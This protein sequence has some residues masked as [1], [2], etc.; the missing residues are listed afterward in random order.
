MKFSLLEPT[1]LTIEDPKTYRL[2]DRI[3]EADGVQFLCPVCF[4]QNQ[5]RV[6]THSIICWR[7]HVSQEVPP[8]PGRWEFK[9]TGYG[10]L[11]L[12]AGSSS[13]LLRTS[14]CKAHFFVENGEVRMT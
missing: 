4:M 8:T 11:T 5:G 1:F 14:P 6:G 10:D 3:G 9:G 2:T 7:P 12:F 13:I